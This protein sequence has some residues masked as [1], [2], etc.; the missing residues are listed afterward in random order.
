MKHFI[1]LNFLLFF[2]LLS[3]LNAQSQNGN[4]KVTYKVQTLKNFDTKK[5]DVQYFLEKS[6]EQIKNLT[7]ELLANK[8]ES[9]F[10][11]MDKVI[12]DTETPYYN[13][14]LALSGGARKQWY[15]NMTENI[16]LK[17]YE[18]MGEPFLIESCL[19]DI[20]WT[21]INESKII[22]GYKTYKATCFIKILGNKETKEVLYEVWYAPELPFATGPMGLAGLPGLILE[23][24]KG[25]VR[26]YADSIEQIDTF[27]IPKFDKGKRMKEDEFNDFATEKIA[28]FRN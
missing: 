17:E 20:S 23:S 27:N 3:L 26:I 12:K 16:I 9:F 24:N 5:V 11:A 22:A 1:K 4:I 28:N 19:G 6:D 13:M 18:F 25:R 8:E 21:L 7:F 10:S 14:A 2:C 15:V